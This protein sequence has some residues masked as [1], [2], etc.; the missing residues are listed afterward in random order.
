M[1]NKVHRAIVNSF[2]ETIRVYNLLPHDF[3]SS[4]KAD[5]LCNIF[6]GKMCDLIISLFADSNSTYDNQDRQE[7]YMSNLPSGWGYRA[8]DHYA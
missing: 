1:A 3:V 8:L 5:K 2:I 4:K 6:Q 7:V